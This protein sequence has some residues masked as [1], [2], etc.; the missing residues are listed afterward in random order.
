[1]NQV[2]GALRRRAGV[3]RVDGSET[4]VPQVTGEEII[5]IDARNEELLAD[6]GDLFVEASSAVGSVVADSL[7]VTVT[8][9]VREVWQ[10]LGADRLN[11]L[12]SGGQSYPGWTRQIAN[13]VTEAIREAYLNGES[14]DGAIGRLEGVVGPGRAE[15]VARTELSGL[16]NDV[17]YRQ[18]S[19]AG[20]ERKRWYSVGDG[21]TRESHR[22]LN[23]TTVRF[24]EQFNVGGVM[25]DGPHA[26]NLPA[27]EVVNCRCRLIP[28]LE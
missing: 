17:S 10:Q 28:V 18:M 14:V 13:D 4:S 3:T 22:D 7:D 23:G 24:D 19:D 9:T 15:A 11:R 6:L 2:V 26:T 5:D 16:L 21:R 20:V 12:V 25:A 1:L 8:D 27:H